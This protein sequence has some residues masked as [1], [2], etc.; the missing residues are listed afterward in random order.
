M[1]HILFTLRQ[2]NAKLIDDE[3]YVNET[4]RLACDVAGAT[5]LK[6]TSH[7]FEPQGT[8]AVALLSES[9]ISFHSWP[10]DGYAVCDVF[11]CSDGVKAEDAVL[12]MQKRFESP[13]MTLKK[14]VQRYEGNTNECDT[15]T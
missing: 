13:S 7:K 14:T 6:S 10:E 15:V 5:F 8:T 1:K 11:T 2:C 9:H 12:F 4:L 3:D